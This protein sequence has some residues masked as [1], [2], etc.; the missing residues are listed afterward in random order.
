MLNVKQIIAALGPN[1]CRQDFWKT[2][3]ALIEAKK[4]KTALFR[5]LDCSYDDDFE[6][7]VESVAFTI[8]EKALIPKPFSND[9]RWAWMQRG[10]ELSQTWDDRFVGSQCVNFDTFAELHGSKIDMAIRGEEMIAKSLK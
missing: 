10:T 6:D 8:V 2:I 9:T 5:I 3:D 1:D 4:Y 7:A